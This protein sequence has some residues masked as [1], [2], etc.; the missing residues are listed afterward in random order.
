M[1]VADEILRLQQAKSDLAT[2]IANKGVTVP[3]ATTLD[4][5]AALVDQI[6]QGSVLP[7][8]AE[9]EYLESRNGA[10]IDSGCPH[11]TRYKVECRFKCTGVKSNRVSPFG[12]WYNSPRT[13]LR[14]FWRDTEFTFQYKYGTVT[15][16]GNTLWDTWVEARIESG[17]VYLNDSSFNA[18]SASDATASMPFVFFGSSSNGSGRNIVEMV[19]TSNTFMQISYAKMYLDNILIRDYIPVR[20]GQEGC[21]YDKVT[22]TLF[23]NAGTGNFI[24]GAD[25]N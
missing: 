8:D 6:Q 2:S 4:G 15:Y 14:I 20:V 9:I 19:T 17:K 12:T 21:L 13:C 5:Y 24:L 7:Y 18:S 3:A 11:N 16:T 25:K 23:G 1:S 22:K 10:Y